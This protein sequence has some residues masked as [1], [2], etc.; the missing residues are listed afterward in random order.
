[1]ECFCYLRNV[2]DVSADGKTSCERRFEEVFSGPIIPF[3]AKVQDHPRSTQD[4]AWL[5]Q[6]GKKRTLRRFF[7]AALFV[8][9]GNLFVCRR[10]IAGERRVRSSCQKESKQKF[11]CR[12]KENIF[13]CASCS[14]KLAG[15]SSEVRPSN[16]IRQEIHEGEEHRSDLVGETDEPDSAEQQLEQDELEAKRESW[17]FFWKLH[18]SSLWS[19]KTKNCTCRKK[20][21][22][23]FHSRILMLSGEQTPRWTYCRL[24][25]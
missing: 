21:R 6:F 11:L 1:M 22:F 14:V 18:L 23:L 24:S 5:H 20:A 3:G 7:W 19:I 17:S 25:G 10:G 13:P 2:Q 9:K 8:P 15:K 4:Q 16:R 12:K